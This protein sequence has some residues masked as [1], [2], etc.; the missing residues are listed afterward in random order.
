MTD[1][2]GIIAAGLKEG[3]GHSVSVTNEWNVKGPEKY[4]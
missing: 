1:D 2:I 3:E 4:F